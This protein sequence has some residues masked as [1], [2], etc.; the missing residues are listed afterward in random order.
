[1]MYWI[2]PECGASLD[3]GEKCT[4]NKDKE[5]ENEPPH[6]NENSSFSKK[7]ISKKSYLNFNTKPAKSQ[8]EEQYNAEKAI[9]AQK[10]FCDRHGLT[11][12]APAFD[13]T[14]FYCGKNIYEP[15]SEGNKRPTGYTVEE[16]GR[17]HIFICP[18]CHQSFLD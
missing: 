7:S 6:A 13:G 14:C 11:N 2:C 17:K 16:A 10:A 8:A 9:E 18:H 12:F 3:H 5:N 4:C 15:Y 1:M